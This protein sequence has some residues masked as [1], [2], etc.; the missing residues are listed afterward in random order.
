MRIIKIVLNK[1]R[2]CAHKQYKEKK[3]ELYGLRLKSEH[4]NRQ[5]HA[6]NRTNA[7]GNIIF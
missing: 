4:R 5:E 3:N 7:E 2:R 1:D 6:D